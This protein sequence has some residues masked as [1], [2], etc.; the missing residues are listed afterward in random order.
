MCRTGSIKHVDVSKNLDADGDDLT[1]QMIGVSLSEWSPSLVWFS[2][3]DDFG[4]HSA[5]RACVTLYSADCTGVCWNVA[6]ERAVT[7]QPGISHSL[8]PSGVFFL[9]C[10]F[11]ILFSYMLMRPRVLM[12]AGLL[13]PGCQMQGRD[14]WQG[15]SHAPGLLPWNTT[16]VILINLYTPLIQHVLTRVFNDL[17]IAASRMEP[18]HFLMWILLRFELFDY[19]NGNFSSNDQVMIFAFILETMW[20]C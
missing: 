12:W 5:G 7:G 20:C 6:E 11:C 4:L 8:C 17:Q 1:R 18:N 3:A 19:F 16:I 10:M 2:P 15:C 14:V 13:L 9:F